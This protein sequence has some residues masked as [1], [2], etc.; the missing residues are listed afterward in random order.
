MKNL[1][2]KDTSTLKEAVY[3]LDANGNGFLAIVD[4][5]NKLIGILTDGDIRRGFLN[6]SKELMEV[7]NITPETMSERSK[8]DEI[9][10]KLTKKHKKHMPLVDQNGILIDVFVLD[11]ERFNVKPNWVVI[12]AGGMG[13][14][15][16]ELTRDIPKPMLPLGGKPMIERII[17]LFKSSGYKKFMISV[18]YKSKVI[19]KYFGN[20]KKFGIDVVYLEEKDRL[21]TAGA[22]SLIDTRL[23]TETFFVVNGDV[24]TSLDYDEMLKFHKSNN[25]DA[26]MCVKENSYQ[27]P[28][29][30]IQTNEDNSIVAI[31]EKPT[32]YYYIN[33]G[34]Y[35][36]E[37]GVID[38]LGKNCYSEMTDLFGTLSNNKKIIKSFKLEGH[39]LDL[40]MP[41]DY[42]SAKSQ[43][44]SL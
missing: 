37:P 41:N 25:S 35:T 16:G 36:L 17:E 3:K 43:F 27:I 34:I 33:T 12:M 1:V 31:E 20:G 9:I 7:V 5:N 11:D 40:G 24:I 6:G 30:V 23:I 29:G 21:G 42:Y 39:W 38:I 4:N 14:R 32:N 13:T 22:L 10:Y 2:L 15:L 18:N 28:Y 26:T 44:D 8:K 19:K